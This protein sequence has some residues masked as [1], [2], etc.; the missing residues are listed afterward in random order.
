MKVG[1]L[2]DFCPLI[3]SADSF[4]MV[5]NQLQ[6]SNIIK[7]LSK[8]DFNIANLE[9]PITNNTDHIA[10]I[11]PSFKTDVESIKFLKA[12]KI[13]C[14][15]TANNHITDYGLEG[16]INTRN[17]L[18]SNKIKYAGDW[19][20]GDKNENYFISLESNEVKLAIIFCAEDEFN[21]KLFK[22]YGSYSSEPIS[23]YNKI[24][25]LKKNH[26][27]VIIYPH[28]GIEDFSFPTIEKQK[29]YRF[30]I[31]AG[32]S[33]VIG[34]HT[35][36][37]QGYE[38]YKEKPI[39]YSL[40]NFFYPSSDSYKGGKYGLYVDFEFSKTEFV[41]EFSFFIQSNKNYNIELMDHSNTIE[42]KKEF[43][44][45][46]NVI[47]NKIE[48]EGL[49]LNYINSVKNSY[50]KSLFP[51]NKK[52]LAIVRRSGLIK[53]KFFQKY[54]LLIYNYVQCDTHRLNLLKSIKTYI[55]EYPR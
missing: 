41:F 45:I 11:G 30:F 25:F 5:F 32:A 44:E 36:C 53:T 33:A 28:G 7:E 18:D 9:M 54:L 37:I 8:N 31:D 55:N 14:V 49:W 19:I 23:V 21:S 43:I 51:L 20:K 40:G 2:G 52:L 38:M 47:S 24:N 29:L 27:H 46:S 34:N 12:L 13:N 16:L 17:N 3:G 6:E 42:F 22:N 39:F 10:K 48:L 26:D 35:H 15:S 50:L 4:Q 1:F